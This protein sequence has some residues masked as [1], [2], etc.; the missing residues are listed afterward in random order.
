MGK[1]VD[2]KLADSAGLIGKA[3]DEQTKNLEANLVNS[4]E[5]KVKQNL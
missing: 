5:K 4:I 2:Q 3:I 1:L